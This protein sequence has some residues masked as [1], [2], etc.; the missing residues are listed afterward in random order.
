MVK[1][2]R[3]TQDILPQDTYSWQKIEEVAR[4]FFSL[5]GY[6]EI[7]TPILE[8]ASLFN[9]SL[10]E[11]TEIVQKQMFRVERDNDHLVLRPE[12]TASVIRAYLEN[13]LDKKRA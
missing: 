4:R 6:Q 2:V 8:E 7:R 13:N 5:Y 10:G 9:R 3:G 11:A 12:G 1:R